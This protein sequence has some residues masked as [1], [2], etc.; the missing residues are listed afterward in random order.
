MPQFNHYEVKYWDREDG[1]VKYT[2]R[3]ISEDHWL[4]SEIQ[5]AWPNTHCTWCTWELLKEDVPAP[6]IYMYLRFPGGKDIP[7]YDRIDRDF[8]RTQHR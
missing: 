8:E 6:T 4:D 3:F 2:K 7:Q 1:T 5:E